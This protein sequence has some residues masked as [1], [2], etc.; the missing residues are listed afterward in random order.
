MGKTKVALVLANRYDGMDLPDDACR[1][2]IISALPAY[3][4]L[5]ERFF[6]ERLGAGRVLSERIRT[7]IVQGAGRC[8]RNNRD[9]AAVIIRGER[10]QDFCC[11]DEEVSVMRPDLQAEIEFGLANAEQDSEQ[12]VP[13]LG[14]FLAQSAVWQ[15][16][17]EGIRGL[18][19]SMR[20]Q[21]PPGASALAAAA[22]YEVEAWRATWRSDLHRAV[23]LAQQVTDALIGGEELRPYRA[24]WFYLAAAWSAAANGADNSLTKRLIGEAEGCARTLRWFPHMPTADQREQL[25]FGQEFDDRADRAAGIL[26]RLGIRGSKFETE[27]TK[28]EAEIGSDDADPFAQGVAGLGRFLGYE[29]WTPSGSAA[30]DAI[31]RRLNIVWILFEAK[32]EE[33]P[34]G[35]ISAD[36]VRQAQTH[37][38][39]TQKDLGEGKGPDK[40]LTCIVSRRTKIDPTAKKVARDEVLVSP[41]VLRRLAK[42]AIGVHRSIRSKARAMSHE[43][44]VAAFQE[45]FMAA[46]LGD[47]PIV[48]LLSTRKVSDG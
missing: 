9:Y 4:H 19:Q 21:A 41:E 33:A 42:S 30:P 20:T 38:T 43:Q 11:R 26:Q 36:T 37:Q 3:T 46:D 14:E 7:R 24:F 1:L 22:Q 28:L 32:T 10:L 2:I 23:A 16:A 45:G 27:L 31:W 40:A 44:L 29:S 47:D 18:A 48:R 6:L 5:Q 34:D 8:T 35:V 17:E 13:L 39:W 12:L 15:E 25:A